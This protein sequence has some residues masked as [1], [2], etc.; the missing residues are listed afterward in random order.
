MLQAPFVVSR[1]NEV[2]QRA[3]LLFET[4]SGHKRHQNRDESHLE[5]FPCNASANGRP[6]ASEGLLTYV[7]T[8]AIS[9]SFTRF[10]PTV[11]RGGFA[12]RT[13]IQMSFAAIDG[14][15]PPRGPVCAPSGSDS[16][17]TGQPANEMLGFRPARQL[18]RCSDLAPGN[19]VGHPGET[20]AFRFATVRCEP[21]SPEVR[22]RGHPSARIMRGSS[23]YIDGAAIGTDGARWARHTERSLM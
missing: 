14:G 9:S 18:G 21:G 16:R 15:Q 1:G 6:T 5:P 2:V 3:P 19:L 7:S 22:P 12:F 13:Q 10:S 23:G 20:P 11:Y 17:S 4:L 8:G